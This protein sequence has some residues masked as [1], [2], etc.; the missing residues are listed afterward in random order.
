MAR[1]QSPGARRGLPEADAAQQ[2]AT[3]I[4]RDHIRT[5]RRRARSAG[6]KVTSQHTSL[7][8]YRRPAPDGYPQG[9]T[10][11][12]AAR[13]PAGAAFPAVGKFRTAAHRKNGQPCAT[14]KGSHENTLF[15]AA[16]RGA[17][18]VR[19]DGRAGAAHLRTNPSTHMDEEADDRATHKSAADGA[20]IVPGTS[21]P[22]PAP[23]ITPALKC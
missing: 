11:V 9:A 6:E 5:G 22:T 18:P 4:N 10:P 7:Q 21:L 2:D 16:G 15:V 1:S 8:I 20:D 13:E 3:S 17:G 14:I 12:I 19:P 23:T